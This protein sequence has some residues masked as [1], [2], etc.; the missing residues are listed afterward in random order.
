MR[1]WGA[2]KVTKK[3]TTFLFSPFRLNEADGEEDADIEEEHVTK[4]RLHRVS[5]SVASKCS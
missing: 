4:V 1:I 3:R 2:G 5:A